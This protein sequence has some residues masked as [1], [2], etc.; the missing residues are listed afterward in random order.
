[1][2]ISYKLNRN[3]KSYKIMDD[4]L[5]IIDNGLIFNY[6]NDNIDIMPD[7]KNTIDIIIIRR[8]IYEINIFLILN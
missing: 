6:I 8:N 2:K 4:I 3:K 5:I 7:K 1:M